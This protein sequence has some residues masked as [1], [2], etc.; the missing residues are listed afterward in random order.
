MQDKSTAYWIGYEAGFLDLTGQ[1]PY[2]EN[3]P[4]YDD[5]EMGFQEGLFDAI[6]VEDDIMPARNVFW[7]IAAIVI[8]IG[9]TV[10]ILL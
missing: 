10:I 6:V 5:W 7:Y 4:G 9:L 1:N 3:L 2:S 8:S